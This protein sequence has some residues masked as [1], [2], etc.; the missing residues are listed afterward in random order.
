MFGCPPGNREGQ[1]RQGPEAPGSTVYSCLIVNPKQTKRICSI[2]GDFPTTLYPWTNDATTPREGLRHRPPQRSNRSQVRTPDADSKTFERLPKSTA[3]S[4]DHLAAGF[5]AQYR[6]VSKNPGCHAAIS[7]SKPRIGVC[8]LAGSK[9]RKFNP[10]R[11][12]E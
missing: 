12:R 11:V 5:S 10:F 6:P 9:P 4:C 1:A 8:N 3:G 7:A 2:L